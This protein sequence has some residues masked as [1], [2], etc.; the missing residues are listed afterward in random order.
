MEAAN[1]TQLRPFGELLKA[2]FD[3]YKKNFKTVAALSAV[4]VAPWLVFW[5]GT[6]DNQADDLSGLTFLTS[7]AL[8][9]YIVA[10]IIVTIALYYLADDKH[11]DKSVS[12]LLKLSLSKFIPI[13][14]ISI[15]V[16]LATIGGLILL[17]IPGIIFAIWFSLTTQAV[18]FEDKR[19]VQALKQSREYVRGR[20]WAVF[21]RIILLILVMILAAI[22]VAAIASILSAIVGPRADALNDLVSIFILTPIVTMFSYHLYRSAADTHTVAAKEPAPA[23]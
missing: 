5:L 11:P 16:G 19:G 8:L 23:S 14:W 9:V 6:P 1:S 17:I 3:S 12:G 13:L 10:S 7:I 4:A 2:A 18:L 21:G 15:L 22:I 20:W